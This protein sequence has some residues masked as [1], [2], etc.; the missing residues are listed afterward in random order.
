MNILVTGASG[1]L[2]QSVVATLLSRS[3][4]VRAAVRSIPAPSKWPGTIEICGCDLA[5]DGLTAVLAGVDVVIHLA[6]HSSAVDGLDAAVLG[7]ARLCEAISAS[8]VKRVCHVSSLAVYDWSGADNILDEQCPLAKIATA[9][10][11][12]ARSKLRQEELVRALD[13]SERVVTVVRPGFIWGPTRL[14]VDGV[15]R[16]LPRAYLLVAPEASVPLT[17]VDNCA[18]AVVS[19]ALEG[20]G[21]FNIVDAPSVS[22]RQYLQA[23][24]A[25]TGAS[26]IVI[27]ITYQTGLRLVTSLQKVFKGMLKTKRLPSLVDPIR[28]EGQFK[29]VVVSADKIHRELGW[30]PPMGFAS[31]ANRSFGGSL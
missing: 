29:P 28:F 17:H 27:P 20:E 4:R 30:T 1:F 2:G 21:T 11:D 24:V 15:G 31:A 13:G 5:K 9:P 12:Y 14:W 22:R 7:T 23:Y 3:H 25:G 8:Q 16:R 26:G 10:T 19:A 18:D 6:G